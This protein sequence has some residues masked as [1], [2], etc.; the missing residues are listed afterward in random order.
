MNYE[1]VMSLR[2]IRFLTCNAVKILL[3]WSDAAK[4]ARCFVCLKLLDG[5][6]CRPTI[7]LIK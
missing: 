7:S 1:N 3:T 2:L 5:S 6:R 4:Y